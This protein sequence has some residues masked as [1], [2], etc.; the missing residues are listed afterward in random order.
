ML[1]CNEGCFVIRAKSSRILRV[2]NLAECIGICIDLVNFFLY[3]VRNKH[4]V[5]CFCVQKQSSSITLLV[6]YLVHVLFKTFLFIVNFYCGL[7]ILIVIRVD[8]T[9]IFVSITN[10]E[11]RNELSFSSFFNLIVEFLLK[12]SLVQAY[13]R[14][15]NSINSGQTYCWDKNVINVVCLSFE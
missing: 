3:V 7:I 6:C 12:S 14:C 9:M 8:I 10:L 15:D 11:S 5:R 2:I 1:G 4:R 13:E